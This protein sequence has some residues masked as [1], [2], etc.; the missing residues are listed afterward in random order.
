MFSKLKLLVLDDLAINISLL[1][2]VI[3]MLSLNIYFYIFY[4]NFKKYKKILVDYS[5]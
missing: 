3:N 1:I 5:C 4:K 2:L